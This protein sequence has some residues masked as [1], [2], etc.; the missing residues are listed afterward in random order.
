M[1]KVII[2]DDDAIFREY[3]KTCIHWSDMGAEVAACVGNGTE[4]IE[5][6]MV[7][8][9]DILVLD[10]EMPDTDGLSCARQI[11]RE[12]PDSVILLI[13]GYERFQYAKETARLGIRDILLKPVDKE[14][15]EQILS[16]A[17]RDRGMQRIADSVMHSVWEKRQKN[18]YISLLGPECLDN[19]MLVLCRMIVSAVQE[20]DIAQIYGG[21]KQY[22]E[23][24]R[25][26]NGAP[27]SSLWLY[28]LPALIC[29]DLLPEA[30]HTFDREQLCQSIRTA[31]QNGDVEQVL[32]G[33][34]LRTEAAIRRGCGSRASRNAEAAMVLIQQHYPDPEFNITKLGHM[35]FLHE[36]YLRRIF[37]AA[38]G[39]APHTVLT[40]VRMN[41]AK[42]LLAQG[43]LQVQ[44]AAQMVGFEDPSYFSKCFKQFFGY[45]PKKT[46]PKHII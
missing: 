25:Q 40:E 16:R 42:D 46:S 3:L 27:N 39:K 2:A 26:W 45:P 43:N 37:Q 22:V 19:H 35:M 10:V 21:V 14:E 23:E 38:Y 7:L 8:R 30:V 34:C 13:T 17:L 24:V 6:A 41:A 18:A 29:I 36:G 1:L 33:V 12:L 28:A 4:A 44:Q 31:Q 11:K 15:V 32:C 5:Q 9:P 20:G